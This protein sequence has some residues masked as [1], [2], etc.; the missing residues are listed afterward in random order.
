MHCKGAGSRIG[1]AQLKTKQLL[2]SLHEDIV[3]S[4]ASPLAWRTCL[5]ECASFKEDVGRWV[6]TPPPGLV[7]TPISDDLHGEIFDDVLVH[8]PRHT[9][10]ASPPAC[11]PEKRAESD[12]CD[13]ATT[14][15]TPED[16]CHDKCLPSASFGTDIPDGLD[17]T[18]VPDKLAVLGTDVP[19]KDA[20]FAVLSTDVPD[21]LA[22]LASLGSNVHGSLDGSAV[23][24]TDV[25]DN[26]AGGAVFGKD[27]S[28]NHAGAAVLG[29]DTPDTL[30]RLASLGTNVPDKLAGVAVRGAAPPEAMAAC[31]STSQH[32]DQG[33]ALRTIGIRLQGHGI[34]E[35]QKPQ[36]IQ[37]LVASASTLMI[38]K[39]FST[40][41]QGI[42]IDAGSG[43]ASNMN[44]LFPCA[45]SARGFYLMF[46]EYV[47]ETS[48]YHPLIIKL[49]NQRFKRELSSREVKLRFMDP[50]AVTPASVAKHFGIEQ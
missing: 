28:D 6:P 30:A 27:V 15:I 14:V 34:G 7:L 9:K 17:G 20:G 46:D 26:P 35:R 11:T 31:S 2:I 32:V 10:A 29:T 12:H 24:G 42:K 49:R 36:A 5:E 45:V 8:T 50:A 23:L 38:S 33:Q 40:V 41:E 18:D 25:A 13:V 16:E 1:S 4:D 43:G 47:W 21:E 39:G 48:N 3:L 37:Q 44:L 19:D 22:S